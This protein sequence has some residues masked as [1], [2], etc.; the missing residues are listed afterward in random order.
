MK[1]VVLALMVVLTVTGVSFAGYRIDAQDVGDGNIVITEVDNGMEDVMTY[2]IGIHNNTD[3]VSSISDIILDGQV[4]QAYGYNG[5]APTPTFA[6]VIG[7]NLTAADALLDSHLLNIGALST[8]GQGMSQEGSVVYE[9]ASVLPTVPGVTLGDIGMDIA[10]AVPDDGSGSG[11]G[12]YAVKNPMAGL[13]DMEFIQLVLP[14]DATVTLSGRYT[15]PV[16]AGAGGAMLPF[17]VTFTAEVP[18]PSTIIMLVLGA[19]CLVG[20]RFRRK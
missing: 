8:T 11:I 17:S 7:T 15:N 5:Y 4:C 18:E 12:T 20:F 14:V 9:S 3:G 16:I 6:E 13:N 2:L 19:L 10:T 1:K